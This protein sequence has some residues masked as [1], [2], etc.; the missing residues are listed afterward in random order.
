MIASADNLNIKNLHE[1]MTSK[2]VCGNVIRPTRQKYATGL[3]CNGC[4][5]GEIEK[6]A[7]WGAQL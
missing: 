2:T 4:K 3:G 6:V 1:N 5:A 7:K